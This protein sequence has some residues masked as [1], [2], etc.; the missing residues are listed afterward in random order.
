MPKDLRLKA[1][2]P[3]IAHPHIQKGYIM[4]SGGLGT[5]DAIVIEHPILIIQARLS[6]IKRKGY[7]L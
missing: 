4:I 3:Y 2:Q 6:M 7:V 1:A 5:V